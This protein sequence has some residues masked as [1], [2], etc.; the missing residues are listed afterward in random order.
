MLRVETLLDD[1]FDLPSGEIELAGDRG[2]NH[3]DVAILLGGGQFHGALLIGVCR[4]GEDAG[5][6]VGAVDVQVHFSIAHR[7]VLRGL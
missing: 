5:H 4:R 6:L 7:R 1:P 3:R 2:P